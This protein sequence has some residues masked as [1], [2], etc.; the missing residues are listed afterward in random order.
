V[1][2]TAADPA[3]PRGAPPGFRFDHAVLLVSDLVAAAADF[4]RLGFTVAPGG[5]HAGGASHNALIV[6]ADG[7]YLE[8]IAFRH[9][10]PP[11]ERTG[12]QRRFLR[13][14]AGHEG[15]VDF[16]LLPPDL[17]RALER[18]RRGGIEI[19]GP[20]D[21]GRVRPDGERIAWRLAVPEGVDL[22]FL[23]ADVTPRAL[24]VPADTELRTHANGASG[25]AAVEVGVRD[26]HAS[27]ARNRAL[28]GMDELSG[29]TIVLRPASADGLQRLRL[30][31]ADPAPRP[32]AKVLL[33]G[34]ALEWAD[35][36][37]RDGDV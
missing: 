33:H 36:K 25:V 29:T 10:P 3:A 7:G 1:T 37:A 27:I 34:A 22:P 28:F 11:A 24:R 13:F 5:E 18:A 31:G 9:V 16:A 14:G 2:H 30:R 32:L 12:F 15:L 4:A 17:D 35:A 26:L 19:D 6:F 23:C 21:G 8:L 20:I